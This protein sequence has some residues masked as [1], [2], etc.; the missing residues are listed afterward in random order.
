[1]KE[2]FCT[3]CVEVTPHK[4]EIDQNGEYV[5]TCQNAIDKDSKGNAIFCN[6]NVKF[7][8]V[9]SPEELEQLITD[10]EAVNRE[11]AENKQ[12]HIEQQKILSQ[13]LDGGAKVEVAASEETTEEE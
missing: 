9:T 7:P 2:I 5:F 3:H 10:R 4:G 11:T 12:S 13:V 6:A 1:M 8:R